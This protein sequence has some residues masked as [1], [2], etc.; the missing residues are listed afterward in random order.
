MITYNKTYCVWIFCFVAY[1]R[2]Q[3]STFQML[4]A[5][6]IVAQSTG[7]TPVYIVSNS[8][9]PWKLFCNAHIQDHKQFHFVCLVKKFTFPI[10]L[11]VSTHCNKKLQFLFSNKVVRCYKLLQKAQFSWKRE[12]L[13]LFLN[14]KRLCILCT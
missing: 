3:Q 13:S 10:L 12:K 14:K 11:S 5:L 4:L 6:S 9:S 7:H 1:V 2:P 8:I